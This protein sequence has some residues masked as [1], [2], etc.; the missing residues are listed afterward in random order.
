MLFA[1]F[2]DSA[3][4]RVCCRARYRVV[5]RV[6]YRARVSVWV[7]FVWPWLPCLLPYSLPGCLSCC[8]PC[9]FTV[10]LRYDTAV[11]R[12]WRRDSTPSCTGTT[13]SQRER[14]RWCPPPPS[15]ER[16][17]RTCF[18]GSL[19]SRRSGRGAYC[20]GRAAILQ[21]YPCLFFVFVV[22]YSS[23]PWTSQIS[24]RAARRQGNER[25]HTVKR[26]VLFSQTLLL[27]LYRLPFAVDISG[28]TL[29]V[30]GHKSR[31]AA[32]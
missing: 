27:C 32:R 19:S 13:T 18:S 29:P 16:A 21:L 22:H 12:L 3:C 14:C 24:A 10:L 11:Q 7:P 5:Y 30:R 15:P 17:S 23:S 2:C 9:L 1:V 31:A 28:S 20:H 8:L 6:L 26:S 4:Y 25:Y